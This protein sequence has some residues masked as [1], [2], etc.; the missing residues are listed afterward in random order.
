MGNTATLERTTDLVDF[1]SLSFEEQISHFHDVARRALGLWGFPEDSG[2]KLLNITENATF[3]VD[4]PNG[5]CMVMRVHRIDY[6]QKDS[7]RT[8]LAWLQALRADT[9]IQVV[10]PIAALD[11]S[12]VQ[13]INTPR[14][15]EDRHVVCFAYVSGKAPRDSHDDN[16]D[17]GNL[18]KVL[19]RIPK[20]V[21]LPIFRFAA[22]AYARIGAWSAH[23]NRLS[24]EDEAMYRTMG[25]IVAKLHLHAMDWEPPTHYQRIEWDWDAT[26]GKG[27]NN[28]YGTHYHQLRGMFKGLIKEK[29]IRSID[30]CATFIK[31]RLEAYGKP[32]DRYGMI[33]SDL[34]MSNLLI[35][36]ETITVLDFDDCGKGWFMYDVACIL[37]LMEH[38]PDVAHLIEVIMEGYCEVR[39]QGPEE[40]L[41]IQTF[42]MMRRIGLTEALMHILGHVHPGS[43]ESAQLTPEILAFYA[44]GTAI[45]ARKYLKTFAKLPLPTQGEPA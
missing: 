40:I 22:G 44:Q 42:V 17:I 36:G 13:T 6:A 37:G 41:E 11:G 35:Q 2:L 9:D 43:G 5:A 8:E 39:P 25:R 33:H 12:L 32:S 38:R 1:K 29:D 28:Y 10:E 15:G 45:L 7:I 24:P 3:K 21:T 26:F 30:E 23:K 16:E 31:R 34:R 18:V 20:S 4:S 27:W 19:E 14:L